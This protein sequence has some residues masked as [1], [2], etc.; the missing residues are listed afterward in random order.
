M[1]KI[2]LG[3]TAILCATT[4]LA[5]TAD[6]LKNVELQDVQVMSIRADKKTPVAFS[7][8][9]KQALQQVN[10]GKDI[11]YLLSMTPSVTMSSDAGT[12]IGYTGIHVRGTDP[13]RINVTANGVPLN[14]GESS[15]LYWVNI[16]DF[17][18]SVQSMQ[19]QR[20]VGTSTNGAGAFGATV[21]MQTDNLGTKP[22]ATIDLSGGSYYTHKETFRFGTGIM[23]GHWAI[24]GRLSNI[25]SKGY[26]DRASAN[27]ASYFLQGG[28]FSD[29][30]VVK[31]V[32]FNG[33][34]KT[35]HAWDYAS[36]ADM[37]KYGR[38][39]NPCGKYKDA[40]G[41]TVFYDNQT[42]NYH[43]QHYQLILNQRLGQDW[44]LNAALHYTKGSGYYEQ[45]KTDQKLYK[46]W[47]STVKDELSDI[48]RQK[49]MDNDFY[50]A[51]ASVN[52][53]NHERLSASIGGGWNK[54]DGDHFGK[55]VW[56]RTPGTQTINPN[57]TYYDNN[58]KK[59]DANIYGKVNYTLLKGLNGYVDLQYRHVG[60][61]STGTS[62]EFDG[63]GQQLPIEFDKTYDFFNPKF[64]LSYQINNNQQV[65]ISY[66]IAHKEPTRNDFEDMLAE[67]DLVEPQAERL[68]DLEVGYKY[69][70]P[71]FSA[72]ANFYYMDYKNQFVLTGAQDTNGEMIARNIE[73]SYRMGIELS[74]SLRPVKG[75]LWDVNATWSKNRAKDMLLNVID[76]NTWDSQQMNVG[77]TPLAFSPDWIVNNMFRY[78]YN[79][80]AASLMTKYVSKQMMTNSG[81]ESYIDEDNGNALVSAVID[82]YCVSDLD[83]SYTFPL[84]SLKSITVGCTVYNLFNH[85]YES[86]GS[87]GINFKQDANGRVQAF[88]NNAQWFYSWATFSAQAPIHAL[89]HVSFNF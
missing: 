40:N 30:T 20:G 69:E 37:E 85:E 28:Y 45:Y 65:Y 79:G 31:L 68:N 57:Q 29:N 70:S 78:E 47:A 75:F 27:L 24:Q 13:T 7:N 71:L 9:D 88:S 25:A 19:I 67:A 3:M 21:N 12:G 38:R 74:A 36:K 22:F 89:A 42:D 35:Y 59:T 11:P 56:V 48:I 34:E 73:K 6:S 72:G 81:F 44:K 82:A 32:T 23:G 55:L 84:R 77:D 64:G 2:L 51:I 8:L 10:F 17:A 33:Q 52:Y 43:Q 53:D 39:Y 63:V 61:R 87:C 14:D 86:N 76:P 60:Y 15:Q 5:Q 58:A 26:I 62:Q 49:R 66:A 1:K 83:L 18:S 16:G 46:Y 54:Y 50:G 80:F 4:T 41:Q